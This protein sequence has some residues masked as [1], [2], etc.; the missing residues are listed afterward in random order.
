[1]LP[2]MYGNYVTEKKSEGGALGQQ[3][4]ALPVVVGA[5]GVRKLSGDG[6]ANLSSMLEG[7][8]YAGAPMPYGEE[9]PNTFLVLAQSCEENQKI[10]QPCSTNA[11]D[12][13]ITTL[14]ADSV[15]IVDAATASPKAVSLAITRDPSAIEAFAGSQGSGASTWAVYDPN[16]APPKKKVDKTD[17]TTLVLGG[18]AGG[19]VG[20]AAGG[21][22]GAAAGAAGG[23]L[24]ASWLA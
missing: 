5:N 11:R 21:P 19:L 1:M 2:N 24:V 23:A 10:Q 15:V 17:A 16:V 14:E 13:L 7:L 12:A 22:L 6:N 4:S 3:P 9:Y 20:F 18:A 8:Y